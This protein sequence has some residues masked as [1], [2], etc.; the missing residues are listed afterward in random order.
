[1]SFFSLTC[2]ADINEI[3]GMKFRQAREEIIRKGWE[4]RETYLKNAEG[5][6]RDYV[7][8]AVFFKGG[9]PEVEVCAGTGVNPCIFNYVKGHECLRVFTKGE[10]I[11]STVVTFLSRECP[12]REA[13]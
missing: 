10:Q 3:V 12:P 4:P 13:Q 8:T 11:E 9:F 6:E 1:M 5:L 7:S 2:S